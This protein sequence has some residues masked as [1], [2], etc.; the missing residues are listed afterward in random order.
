MGQVVKAFGSGRH[1][2]LKTM[3]WF[4]VETLYHYLAI[5]RVWNPDGSRASLP[6]IEMIATA[7]GSQRNGEYGFTRA[8]VYQYFPE[9]FA[10]AGIESDGFSSGHYLYVV[11]IADVGVKYGYSA[12]LRQR[13]KTHVASAQNHKRSVARIWV[14]EPHAY[15]KSNE[16]DYKDVHGGSEY[17][18]LPFEKV[19]SDLMAMKDAGPG[20]IVDPSTLRA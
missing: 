9:L 14:S 20:R 1:G 19:T 11:E 4:T 15:A 6:Q 7:L 10:V 8:D 3:A 16:S 17:L 5:Y 2:N 13:L 12:N 18:D